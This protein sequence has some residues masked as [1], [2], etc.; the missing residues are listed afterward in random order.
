VRGPSVHV[1]DSEFEG[2]VAVGETLIASNLAARGSLSV[3]G[4]ASV[5]GGLSLGGSISVP[6]AVYTGDSEIPGDVSLVACSAPGAT[7]ILPSGARPGHSVTIK[8]VSGAVDV[9][10]PLTVVSLSA[11]IEGAAA[12]LRITA[13]SGAVNVFL[14]ERL[15]W[16]VASAAGTYEV[17]RIHEAANADELVAVLQDSAGGE[18]VLLTG[19]A[20]YELAHDISLA[21]PVVIRPSSGSNNVVIYTP[22]AISTSSSAVVFDGVRIEAQGNDN[23]SQPALCALQCVT[24]GLISVRHSEGACC[25]PEGH[26]A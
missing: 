22:H 15:G 26:V 25:S 23:D 14:T 4:P 1:A 6:H 5:S 21:R 17:A 7:L 12:G 10:R 11:H 3:D 2:N 18:L 19:S 20:N 9:A 24:P 13:P 8:D 16:V